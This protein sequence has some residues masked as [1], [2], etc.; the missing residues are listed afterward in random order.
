MIFGYLKPPRTD[1]G[2]DTSLRRLDPSGEHQTSGRTRSS[3]SIRRLAKRDYVGQN[4]EAAV[5]RYRQV[6]VMLVGDRR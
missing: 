2:W 1:T 3:E 5:T 4:R 6:A